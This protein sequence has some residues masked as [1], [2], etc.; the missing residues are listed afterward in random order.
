MF[1]INPFLTRPYKNPKVK[2]QRCMSPLE[3]GMT[4]PSASE[5]AI[6]MMFLVQ[7]TNGVSM[8]MM[9]NTKPLSPIVGTDMHE[10]HDDATA[11][12]YATV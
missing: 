2:L 10:S 12:R 9:A 8:P 6:M 1:S 3:F 5:S 11:I 4:N 7:Y